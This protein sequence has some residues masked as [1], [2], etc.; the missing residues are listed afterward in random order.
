MA[1][2]RRCRAAS[3]D[4]A[5]DVSNSTAT[6]DYAPV[7]YPG[8]TSSASAMRV[9]MGVSEERSGLDVQLPLVPMGRVEGLVMNAAGPAESLKSG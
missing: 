1:T 2:S 9:T 6:N 4:L 8:T 3:W 5:G 7:F